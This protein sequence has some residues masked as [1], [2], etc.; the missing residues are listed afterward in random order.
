[1]HEVRGGRE[2][3]PVIEGAS[4]KFDSY[5]LI[6][7]A[8]G[9]AAVS[10][11]ILRRE[12]GP[13]HLARYSVGPVLLQAGVEGAASISEVRMEADRTGIFLI[14]PNAPPKAVN[15]VEIGAESAALLAPDSLAC[16]GSAM[17]TSWFSLSANPVDLERLSTLLDGPDRALPRGV[18]GVAEGA[19]FDVPRMRA[20]VVEAFRTIQSSGQD[21]HPEAALNLGRTLLRAVTEVSIGL[22]SDRRSRRPL[23]VDR[24]AASRSIFDYLRSLSREPVYIEQICQA[25]KIPE[26]TLRLLFLEQFGESPMRVLRSRRLCLVHQALQAPGLGL[27]EI[28]LTAERLG[29]WHMGEFSTDYRKLFGYSPS[30]TVRRSRVRGALAGLTRPSERSPVLRLLEVPG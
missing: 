26:R 8:I 18:R 19:G 12:E 30:D 21:L 17:P 15:G 6:V 25:T 4:Q 3:V 20:F 2:E 28:R 11:S 24:A 14:G 16:L 27:K 5:E 10:G 29:F 22:S 13:W 7:E 23:R 9:D 1:M